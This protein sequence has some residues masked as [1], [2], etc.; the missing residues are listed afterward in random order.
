MSAASL[1][2]SME[3][4]LSGEDSVL[5]TLRRVLVA[6]SIVVIGITFATSTI[7][8]KMIADGVEGV[9]LARAR[10]DHATQ[11]LVRTGMIRVAVQ[12]VVLWE[13]GTFFYFVRDALRRTSSTGRCSSLQMQAVPARAC[14]LTKSASS[15]TCMRICGMRRP[16]TSC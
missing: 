10:G 1:H 16:R 4:G 11:Y 6:V 3:E 13:E 5:V 7:S 12:H 15:W 14:P 9:Q 8:K 2:R